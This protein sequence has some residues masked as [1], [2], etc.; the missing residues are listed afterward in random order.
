MTVKHTTSIFEEIKKNPKFLADRSAD[1]FKTKI[2]ELSPIAPIDRANLLAQTRDTMQTN[3]LLPGTLTFFSYDPKYKETLPY[4]D[5]FPLSFIVGI[6][7]SGFTGVNF[8]YLTIPMRIKLYDAMYTIA[9]QSVNKTTQQVLV[10]NWKL[11]SNFSKFP[12]VAPA[13]KKYLFGHVQS[14][15]IKVPLEDWKTAIL[16]ENAEFKKASAGNVRTISTKIALD[17]AKNR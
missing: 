4:Y 1:W 12:A 17:A 10:L 6:D 8:H 7:R 11:L 3:R 16:L 2:K 5:K 14:R 13:V 9:R 15:F